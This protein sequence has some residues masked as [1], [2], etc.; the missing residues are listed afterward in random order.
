MSSN[1]SSGR[2]VSGF[3]KVLANTNSRRNEKQSYFYS[4][5]QPWLWR[6]RQR[7]W[8]NENTHN[9]TAGFISL[10]DGVRG[11]KHVRALRVLNITSATHFLTL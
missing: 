11:V 4:H 1:R 10:L 9:H 3:L 8:E 5:Y 6:T 7:R 2:L